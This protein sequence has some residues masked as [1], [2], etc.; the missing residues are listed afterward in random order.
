MQETL[1]QGAATLA[2][3]NISIFPRE[4]WLAA[5]ARFVQFYKASTV[6]PASPYASEE[7][8]FWSQLP[9][10]QLDFLRSKTIELC[11]P[12]PID[13]TAKEAQL[14]VRKESYEPDLKATPVIKHELGLLY[15]NLRGEKVNFIYTQFAQNLAKDAERY[16]P[17][18]PQKP[19]ARKDDVHSM[20]SN[21][22][23][24]AMRVGTSLSQFNA[25]KPGALCAVSDP[26][27]FGDTFDATR[28]DDLAAMT[29][30]Q[31]ESTKK[32]S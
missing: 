3:K 6:D 20:H 12:Q 23:P 13:R 1:H 32:C 25:S 26:E 7:A 8:Y 11:I 22:I 19:A 17:Q 9:V 16:L 2:F 30:R 18:Q 5:A 14:N 28:T 15:M 27:D 31:E 29:T 10:D 21:K 24:I 4:S